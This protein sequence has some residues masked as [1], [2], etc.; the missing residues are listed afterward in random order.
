MKKLKRIPSGSGE[1]Y[2]SLSGVGL[3]FPLILFRCIDTI[4]NL[5]YKY[6]DQIFG[7]FVGLFV[8]IIWPLISWL[9][10]KRAEQTRKIPLQKMAV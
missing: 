5:E 4:D 8:L 10:I 6:T 2:S 3:G 9:Q 1:D 7:G